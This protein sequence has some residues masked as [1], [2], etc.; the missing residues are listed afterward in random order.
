[1]FSVF[2]PELI[3]CLDYDQNNP[4]HDYDLLTHLAKTVSR[5]PKDA[6][7]RLAGLLHDIGKPATEFKDDSGISHFYGHSA[8]SA[9]MAEE[10]LKRLKFSNAE[11]ARIVTLIR[12]HDGVIDETEK[13]VKRKINKL[14]K[15]LFFDLLSLQRADHESQKQNAHF[16]QEHDDVIFQIANNVISSQECLD[17][18][19]LAVSGLD[20]QEIGLCGQQIGKMLNFLLE[21]VLDGD[22]PNNREALLSLAISRSNDWHPE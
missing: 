16:R 3:P 17:A 13:A 8:K 14:G 18:K 21:S 22:A 6:T 4:H 12:H 2:L 9:T 15:Y 1:V 5:L 19:Q 10:I 20:M 11:T 7:L